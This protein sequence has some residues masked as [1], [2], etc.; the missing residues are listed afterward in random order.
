MNEAETR[1]EHIDPALKAAGWGVVEGS[2]IRREFYLTPGRIEGQG[3][4]GKPL[5]ADYILEYR[6]QKLA[7]VEAKAWDE[8]LTEG[9][10]QAKD[11]ANKLSIRFAYSSNGRGVYR[12]DMCEGNEGEVPAFPSPDELWDH[13][14][15]EKNVWRDRFATIS[16]PNKGGSWDLRYYQEIAVARVLEQIA[17]GSQRILLTLATGTGKTSIAFQIAW[18]LF[19][20]RW[21]LTGE[22]TRRPRILF[23][24][25]RNT[26]ANQAFNDFNSFAAF[27]DK[28]LARI[29]PDEIRKKGRVPK[30]A[31]VFFTIFQT[32]MSGKDAQG[33][34]APY[35]G[36]YPPDFF[37]FIVIDEC[38]RGGAR[39]EST[40]HDILMYFKPA[41]QL[42]LTATPKR[43]SNVD[44]YKYFG[45][46]VYRYS[47]RDGINDGFLTPFKVK[48]I[49][50]TLDDYTY[51]PDDAIVEG[52][53]VAGKRYVENE[54]NRVIIIP[55]REKNRVRIFMDAIDQ[56][57]KTIVFCATQKH[58]LMVRDFVNQ[59]KQ[60]KDPHYCERVTA[61]DG[62]LGDQ[63]LRDFQ[64]NDKTIP[65]IL[66]TS[67]KLST[68]VDARNVR[69]IV[70]MRPI[71]SIIEFK[72]IIGRGTRLFDGKDHFTIYD[73]VKAYQHFN[74]PE[75]DG[76]PLEPEGNKAPTPRGEGEEPEPS[77]GG[78]QEPPERS[79]KLKI[80]LA[81]GKER[82]IQHMMATTFWGPDGK[83][84]SAAQFVERLFGELPALFT[85]EDQLRTLWSEPET[86]RK[87]LDALSDKG[88]GETELSAIKRMID[89]EKS[90][91][92][93]VL[94]Y[95]AF[96]LAPITREERV[97]ARKARIHSAYDDE[98]LRT[99][100]D[101][102]LGE[103]VKEG[104][105]ELDNSKLT[106]LLELRYRAVSDAV[107]QLGGIP[108]IRDAFVGFQKLLYERVS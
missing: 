49:A 4:R 54:F 51:T 40:W 58:A 59:L 30:N 71:N 96:A 107:Q 62:A 78:E 19:E 20:A 69:N 10:G 81:D 105:G 9:V 106:P 52:E 11:Y 82:T 3:R 56:N 97:N 88:F 6:N 8:E 23:L 83:P 66:T 91:L 65:T 47:L 13:T 103:Y 41:A 31:S 92:Y 24:A 17:N 86:R 25:D 100:L 29:D 68:G 26:L 28:A 34:P 61:D 36:E 35:F 93:D 16:Y 15:A 108:K 70:L 95:I 72:Q 85:D 77:G 44:T 37:D 39:D 12:I 104:V 38:H 75:W 50:T 33:N 27:E 5:K 94:A 64:D 1:A 7:V 21:N 43:K 57:E 22:P 73:F 55:E 60:S 80:Q 2:R 14:F 63:H 84:M 99:F 90:D 98:K 74:D 101:F 42:G 48:Q 53:V 89:A 76:E 32:F 46:P 18:K 45:E 67:Q 102:V 79:A 87:L